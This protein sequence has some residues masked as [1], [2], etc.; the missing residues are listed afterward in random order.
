MPHISRATIAQLGRRSGRTFKGAR[1]IHSLLGEVMIGDRNSDYVDPKDI[2]ELSGVK[3]VC[4]EKLYSQ[5][6][7]NALRDGS[8]EGGERG[9][10][11]NLLHT[12]D[13]VVEVG[14]ALGCVTTLAAKIIGSENVKAFEA[15]PLLIDDAL[16]NFSLNGVKPTLQNS[17]LCNRVCWGGS[18]FTEP[19]YIHRDFWA[20][21]MVDKPGTIDKLSIETCCFEDEIFKFH[22]NVL[23]CDIE[24]GEIDLLTLADLRGIEKILLEIHYWAGREQ[25]N[26]LVRKLILDGFTINFD[27]TFR[28]IVTLRRGLK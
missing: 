6:I 27:L 4:R 12:G 13:R 1:Y 14:S 18:G 21:S 16:F 20:S 25:I 15:N 3:I 17:I 11:P 26:K 8:Y 9:V 10:L 28:S 22:A 7:V 23:I 24:G 5:A 2:V 19:F